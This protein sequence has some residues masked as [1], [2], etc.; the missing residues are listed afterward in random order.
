MLDLKVNDVRINGAASIAVPPEVAN[1][2][3]PSR[4]N[5][6]AVNL[7][8]NIRRLGLDVEQIA[9]LHGPRVVTLAVPRLAIGEQSASR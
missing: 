1:A 2:P 6:Y 5:P 9:A 7:H 8:D 3:A 4:A